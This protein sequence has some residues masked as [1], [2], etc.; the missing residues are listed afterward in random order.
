MRVSNIVYC[1][2][3]LVVAQYCF[4]IKKIWLYCG[5]LNLQDCPK[6]ISPARSVSWNLISSLFLSWNL[7]LSLFI[8][9]NLISSCEISSHLFPSRKISS[10]DISS[11]LFSFDE[12]SSRLFSSHE[13]SSRLIWSHLLSYLNTISKERFCNTGSGN[14]KFSH[15][16]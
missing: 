2:C 5:I 4:L 3:I 13:I 8:S 12:I 14:K 1:H 16:C 15:F 6:R 7:I 11:H 9:W 10:H